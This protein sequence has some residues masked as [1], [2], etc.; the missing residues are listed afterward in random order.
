MRVVVRLMADDDRI[1]LIIEGLPEDE[2]QVRLGAF[3]S[4]LQNLNATI[5]KLDRENNDGKAATYYRIVELSYNSPVRVVL[6]PHSLPKHSYIGPAI[7]D[8]LV[9]LTT[10]LEDGTEDDLSHV[11]ADLLEDIRGLTRPVGKSVKS[12]SLVFRDRTFD[13]S[14]KITGKVD[15]ALAVD[16]ECEGSVIGMLEQINL[17]HDANVFHIYPEIGP[18]KLRCYFRPSLHD[19]AV[20]AVGK[21]VE[22]SGT[23]SYRTGAS[24]PHQVW[25]N[26]IEAFP[27]ES[28]LPDWEDLRG[29][30]PD[31]T[32]DL[33]S[34]AYVRELR[35]GWR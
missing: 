16:E 29:R 4:Q 7:L 27:P 10:A 8:S 17:H 28:D 5:S 2:G 12:S 35:S 13:L 19:E 25:V 1:T 20:F 24:F 9:R 6:E 14:E 26:G 23:L 21:R 15:V 30:A 33:S 18:R 32:G 3:M 22:V 31:V 34:E 11:D